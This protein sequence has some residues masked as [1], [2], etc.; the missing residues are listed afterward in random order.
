MS[1]FMPVPTRALIVLGLCWLVVPTGLRAQT[2]AQTGAQERTHVSSPKTYAAERHLI[3]TTLETVV[4]VLQ[5]ATFQDT[6]YSIGE[7]LRAMAT[8]LGSVRQSFQPMPSAGTPPPAVTRADLERLEALLRDLH[9]QLLALRS[10]LEAEQN[11]ALANRLAPVERGLFDAA[12]TVHGMVEG[13]RGPTVA[14]AEGQRWLEP[15]HYDDEGYRPLRGSRAEREH[16]ERERAERRRSEAGRAVDDAIEGAQDGVE[17]GIEGAREGIRAGVEGAREGIEDARESIRDTFGWGRKGDRDAYERDRRSRRDYDAFSRRAYAITL[18]D[19]SHDWPFSETALY[20]SLPAIRYNRVEGLVLGVGLPPLRWDDYDRSHLYGQAGY[21]FALDRWRVTVGAETQLAGGY[22][23]DFGLKLGAN[24]HHNTAT[25][26]TWKVNWLENSLAA[27]LFKYDFFD[28]YEIQGW[29]VYAVQ[30]LSPY[31][32][33]SAGFR[34]DD[35][36]SLDRNTNWALFGGDPFRVNP[37]IDEGDMRSVVLAFEGG[38]VRGIDYLPRGI[39]F[40]T[41]A[42]FGR[43]MGGDFAFNRYLGDVRV[44]LPATHRSAVSLRLR[45]GLLDGGDLPIQKYFT[46]GGVGSVRAYPQNAFLGTRMLLAN[47][48]YATQDFSLVDVIDDVQFLG[49]ADAGWVN[50]AGTDAFRT[51]DALASAGLGLAFDDRQI[52]LELAWPLRDAGY[53]LGPSL[54]LRLNPSF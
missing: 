48:E 28:Y 41:E 29:T 30:Q 44:Y 53:G 45:G 42:E 31:T 5:E 19:F 7:R 10:E 22:D 9:A 40:R 43:G 20:R 2:G 33:L 38:R 51:E 34:H 18:N 16:A 39:A 27:F 35:Y 47:V 6:G 15:G 24:Y 46:L 23:S 50:D 3:E 54:W 14:L 21:A 12:E 26:D 25:D 36:R 4:A 1:R 49:F 32:Q 11:V 37:W 8:Q 52:R 17:A 13:E